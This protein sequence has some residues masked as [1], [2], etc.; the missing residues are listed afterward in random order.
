MGWRAKKRKSKEKD[1]SVGK[2][3]CST[4]GKVWQDQSSYF[5]DTVKCGKD[6][7]PLIVENSKGTKPMN[8]NN[9]PFKSRKDKAVVVRVSTETVPDKYKAAD[10]EQ[11][12]YEEVPKVIVTSMRME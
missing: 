8:L 3:T 5:D 1:M 4:C 6:Y 11:T 9:W 12:Y 2:I 10:D 7:C